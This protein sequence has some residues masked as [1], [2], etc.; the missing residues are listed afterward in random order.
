APFGMGNKEPVFHFKGIPS[1]MRQLG[2]NKQHLKLQFREEKNAFDVIGFQFGD[3]YY[4]ISKDIEVSVVGKLEI[5]EWNGNRTVQM[6]LEDLAVDSWQLFDYRAK[7]HEKNIAPYLYHYDHAV[8]LGNERD[9]FRHLED[10][11]P[12]TEIITYSEENKL[13]E[14]TDILF[15][16]D[17]PANLDTLKQIVEEINPV[18]IHVSYHVTDDAYLQTVPHREDF[19]WLYGFL[20]T[21]QPIQLKVDLVN[22]MKQKKWSKEKVIFM[23]K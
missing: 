4:F 8:I 15:I 1:Q 13:T 6:M 21:Y 14:E 20:I 5:N 11:Y 22:I 18:N 16:C 23:L 2:Q 17:L 3:L 9:H 7:H 10:N 12:N 19:K